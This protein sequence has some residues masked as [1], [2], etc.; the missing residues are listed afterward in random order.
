MVSCLRLGVT[1][2]GLD[3][4]ILISMDLF[5]FWGFDYNL[6]ELCVWNATGIWGFI[7]R[8]FILPS[9]MCHLD[10]NEFIKGSLCSEEA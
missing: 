6:E 10:V 2:Q 3:C 5:G 7:K 9:G 4:L 1:R 8:V